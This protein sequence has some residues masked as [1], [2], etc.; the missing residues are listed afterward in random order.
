[1]LFYIEYG[2]KNIPGNQHSSFHL[3]KYTLSSQL[4]YSDFILIYYYVFIKL[5]KKCRFIKKKCFYIEEYV[6][7]I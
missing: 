4:Q 5:Y 2:K 1:M 3:H 7:R 6:R